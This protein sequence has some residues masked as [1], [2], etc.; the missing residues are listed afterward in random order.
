MAG[1]NQTLRDS[2][3]PAVDQIRGIPGALGL[4]LFTVS[5]FKRTWSGQRVGLG[6]NTDTTSGLKVD[7]GIFQTKI[8]LLRMEEIIVSGGLY[9]AQ[10]IEVGPI[11]PP[12][13]GS[14]LDND[15]ISIFDPPVGGPPLELFFNIQGPG[16]ASGGE[17]FKKID[18]NVTRN[19]R[20]MFI[21]RKTAEIP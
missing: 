11:T 7:L 14:T 13:T 3:L 9:S 20:Y 17:F 8:R 4:R 2:L 16:F 19:F 1:G 6:S 18:Q 15:A 12:F 21:V 5:V 10:D